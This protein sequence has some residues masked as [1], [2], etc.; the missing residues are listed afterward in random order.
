[1][2]W[3]NKSF[4]RVSMSVSNSFVRDLSLRVNDSEAVWSWRVAVVVVVVVVVE[5]MVMDEGDCERDDKTSNSDSSLLICFTM[6]SA[7]EWFNVARLLKLVPIV[8]SKW[9]IRFSSA[10]SHV[11]NGAVVVAC[12][13]VDCDTIG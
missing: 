9:S 1:M 11:V 10:G 4:L 7:S 6:G 3:S 5:V 13:L 8:F 2:L 12:E